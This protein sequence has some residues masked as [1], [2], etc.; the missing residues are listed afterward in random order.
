MN[1]ID[2]S[3]IDRLIL[4]IRNDLDYQKYLTPT[5]FEEENSKFLDFYRKGIKYNPKYIYNRFDPRDTLK[6]HEELKN[7]FVFDGTPLGRIYDNS[8]SDL[9]D[10]IEMYSFVGTSH[11]TEFAVKLN[12]YPN[13]KYEEAAKS[14]LLNTNIS[15]A[16]EL[17]YDAD[18]M[19]HILRERIGQYG[20]SWRV[21]TSSNM[22]ARVSVEP[23]SKTVYVNSGKQFSYNDSIRLQVHEIDTHVLRTEN[24]MNRGYLVLSSGTPNSLIHEE[25][26]AIFNEFKE[27]VADSF[28]NSLYG[29]RFLAGLNISKS[30][31]DIFDMLIRLGCDE[32]LSMYVV[33]RF[34]RGLEDTSLPGGF[35]KDYVYFQGLLELTEAVERDPSIYNKMYYGSI[36]LRD[37]LSLE[38]SISSAL[39]EERIILPLPIRK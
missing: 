28:S 12:H 29:A 4:D 34:K 32:Y 24:G 16:E 18:T 11:F 15:P 25:G 20:F 27:G 33:S 21:V 6:K 22:A 38:E 9:H 23:E 37:V 3:L 1:K 26:L 5:N 13:I 31:F 8:I 35:I 2:Y 14:S 7:T 17:L 36:S 19:A 10:E 39:S 30:F